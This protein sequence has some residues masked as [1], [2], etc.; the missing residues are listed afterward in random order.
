M[1]DSVPAVRVWPLLQYALVR[2]EHHVDGDVAVRVDSDLPAVAMRVLDGLVDLLLR[3][4]EDTVVVRADVRCAHAHGALG[5]GPVRAVL[6]AAHTH[7]LVAESGRDACCLELLVRPADHHVRAVPE[8]TVPVAVLVR[9]DLVGT[10]AGVVNARE[11]RRGEQR[12]DVTHPRP[13]ALA[14]LLGGE[15]LAL[16]DTVEHSARLFGDAPVRGAVG[17]TEEP[18]MVRVRSVL[19]DLR[20]LERLA[21]VP[22]R[23]ATTMGDTHQVV[24]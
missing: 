18:P 22:R 24:A 1:L 9:A 7:P 17:V 8:L 21:V 23:V 19:R 14:L 6:H 13:G 16:P 5:R 20:E 15:S 10:R 12:R 2:F 11:P 3:H 4:G